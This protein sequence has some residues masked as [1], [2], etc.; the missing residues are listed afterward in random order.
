M[1]F[2]AHDVPWYK[3]PYRIVQTN[4]REPDICRDPKKIAVSIREFG[5]NAIVSNVGGIVAFYP[6]ELQYHTLNP[7]MPDGDF[8]RSMIDAARAEGLAYIGRF[9]LSKSMGDTFAAHPEWFMVNRDGTPR[10]YAGAYQACPNGGWSQ[11]YVGQI[12]AEALGRY[13]M[14]G[15]FFNGGGFAAGDYTGINRGICV[16]ANC[17][18]R[19]REMFGKDL[20]MEDGPGDPAWRDY[21][22]F[23]KKV[24]SELAERNLKTI[25][26]LQVGIAVIG[27][28]VANELARGETQRR[29]ERPA[30]EWAYQSGEQS[31]HI[32]AMVPGKPFSATSAAHIDY[33]WRQVVETGAFHMVRL[34]QQIGTGAMPDLYLMGTFDDQNDHR[35]EAQV[36]WLFQWHRAN[37]EHYDGLKPAAQIG[38]YSGGGG[39]VNI[40]GKDTAGMSGWRGIYTAM[41]DRRIPF[42][43]VN[44]DRVDDGTT[45]LAN[46]DWDALILPGNISLSE[47]EAQA[48]DNFVSAGGSVITMGEVRLRNVSGANIASMPMISSPI[49]A[50]QKPIDAHGW[51]LDTT[52]STMDFGGARIPI[53]GLYY[54]AELK[55]DTNSLIG[56]APQQFF[57]PPELSY[58]RPETTPLPYAGVLKRA[59]GK[60]V[61]I[62]IPWR[63]DEQYYRDGLPDLAGLF[64]ELIRIHAPPP[65]VRLEGAGPVELM[66]MRQSD[67]SLLIH[68]I[69][70]AGQRNGLYA[71]PPFIHGLRLGVLG[72]GTAQALVAGQEVSGASAPDAAG[73]RW[74]DLPP[75]GFFEAVAVKRLIKVAAVG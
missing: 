29:V 74:Y 28:G 59:F 11:A 43:V 26:S 32:Q 39:Q 3:R 21:L 70:Y 71:D 19:F 7:Y 47:R 12:L 2:N 34:A 48:I 36:R 62:H 37:E 56:L 27:M 9:D 69:N 13:E 44:G 55:P 4:L 41:V 38:L 22:A 8:V 51:S 14:D 53:D 49:S 40:F 16:C 15:I 64:A 10:E 67:E 54:P 6:T 46:E 5:G 17:Q 18:A 35:F 1:A 33:P 50:Y 31:R 20:P 60:G 68:V 66:A 57:G 52:N 73:Y 72:G 58:A 45:K 63:P 24:T 42:W 75:V 61:A 25:K 65:L 23:Q 30:P